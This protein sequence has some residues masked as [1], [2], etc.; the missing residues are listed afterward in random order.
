ME[1]QVVCPWCEESTVA[2]VAIVE[3]DHGNIRERRCAQCN[4][5]LAAYLVDE[6]DFIKSVRKFEN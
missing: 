1:Q 2:K 5:V 6:G 4:K 3:K